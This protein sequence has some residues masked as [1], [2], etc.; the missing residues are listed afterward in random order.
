MIF[1][2][3]VAGALGGMIVSLTK[4][5]RLK[6]TK[7]DKIADDMCDLLIDAITGVGAVVLVRILVGL[8]TI[9][10]T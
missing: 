4:D 10:T 2:L 8:V 7:R 9:L 5:T 6:F 3:A 1:D